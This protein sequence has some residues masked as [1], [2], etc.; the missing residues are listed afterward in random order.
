MTKESEPSKI[1]NI[2]KRNIQNPYDETS[3]IQDQINQI[4]II[5]EYLNKALNNTIEESTRKHIQEI[6][7][8]NLKLERLLKHK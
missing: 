4:T 7:K 8:Y 5:N 1:L 6:K 2:N 3:E